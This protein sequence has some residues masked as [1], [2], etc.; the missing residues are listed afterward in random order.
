MVL[1]PV[2]APGAPSCGLLLRVAK[3]VSSGNPAQTA[4]K[5]VSPRN[6]VKMYNYDV[7]SRR[8]VAYECDVAGL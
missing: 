2:Y 7:L 6:K 4:F 1:L 8:I 5:K 3:N